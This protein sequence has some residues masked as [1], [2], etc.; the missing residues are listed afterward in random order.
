[1]AGRDPKTRSPEAPRL[2]AAHMTPVSAE[3]KSN[4]GG[5]LLPS[6][7]MHAV[8]VAVVDEYPCAVQ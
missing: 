5:C 2:R 8:H 4:V 3:D 6:L 7:I 1:M